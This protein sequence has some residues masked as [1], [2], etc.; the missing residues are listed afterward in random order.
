MRGTVLT[1]RPKSAR[2]FVAAS[3]ILAL[4][5]A[6]CALPQD[7]S[8][9]EKW[10]RARLETGGVQD[11][12]RRCAQAFSIIDNAVDRAG[13]GDAQATSIAG[14]PHLRT[15]RFLAAL[16]ARFRTANYKTAFAGWTEW[17]ART[18]AD[19]GVHRTATWITPA[20][21]ELSY[22]DNLAQHASRL[23]PAAS[24]L[25]RVSPTSFRLTSVA[26]ITL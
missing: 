9:G 15:T 14:F 8:L 24:S 22:A 5:A 11:G 4:V 10:G 25:A 6:A 2:F 16:G 1:H 7:I 18:A 13:T 3:P 23:Q 26:A 17:L 21:A 20:S 12:I 19:L